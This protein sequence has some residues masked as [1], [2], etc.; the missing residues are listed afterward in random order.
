MH[1]T[2]LSPSDPDTSSIFPAI[3]KSLSVAARLPAASNNNRTAKHNPLTKSYILVPGLCKWVTS[4]F[5]LLL[6][7]PAGR[8][9]EVVLSA[10]EECYFGQQVLQGLYWP[11]VSVDH[12]RWTG[13]PPGGGIALRILAELCS[14]LG[15]LAAPGGQKKKKTY[16]G[17]CASRCAQ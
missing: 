9:N 14:F 11:W 7:S 17:A 13:P 4:S 5:F 1:L 12:A 16:E 2:C 8:R 15:D 10:V 3:I 6:S